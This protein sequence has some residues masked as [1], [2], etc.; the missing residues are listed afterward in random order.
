MVGFS[1]GLGTINV[2]L[3]RRSKLE[4]E[5]DKSLRWT[6]GIAVWIFAGLGGWFGFWFYNNNF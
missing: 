4:I 6:Y 3:R 2:L 5:E 1:I